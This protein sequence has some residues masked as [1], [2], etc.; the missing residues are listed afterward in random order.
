MKFLAL[1]F[2][3]CVTFT[4]S[5]QTPNIVFDS[6]E[7]SVQFNR[8]GISAIYSH[9]DT[10]KANPVRFGDA[11]GKAN[12]VYK[13]GSGAWL[14]VNT[15]NTVINRPSPNK[16]VYSNSNE[17]TTMNLYRTFEKFDNKVQCKIK[18]V[19][20]VSFPQTI[21][22]FY[23]DFPVNTPQ[24]FS[25]PDDI[26]EQ[27]YVKHQYIGGNG[28][29]L[30]YTRGSGQPPF[31]VV[32]PNKGTH[33]EYFEN[34]DIYI[35]SALSASKHEKGS[36]R[37]ENSEIVLAPKGE[38][39][40]S[41]EYGFV[42]EWANSYEEIRDILYNNGLFDIRVIPGMTIPKD[43]S[44]KISIRTKNHIDSIVAEYPDKTSITYLETTPDN[45]IYEIE[46]EQLGENLITIHYNHSEKTILEFFSTE[47]IDTLIQ[48][49]AN[50]IAESQQHKD[51]TKWYNGLYSV[52]DMENKKLRGPDDTDGFDHWWGYVL[53]ADDP[54]LCKAP[55]L[56]AKNV[57]LPIDNEIES[58]EYYIEN[59]VW[60]GLQRTDK[61]YP[62]PY[63]IYG[64]PNWKV[65]R[66]G[67]AER[68]EIRNTN[69]D[70]MPV[71]RA[72]DYPHIFMLYYHMFQIAEF[73]PNKV[74]FR[75]AKGYLDLAYNTAK[76]YFT[77]PYE[78]LPYYEIYQWGY[79]NELVL[80]P[81]IDDLEKYG[82]SDEA[83]W[84]R[85]EWEKKVKY[86]IYDDKYPYR[87]EYPFDRTAFESSYALAKYGVLNKMKP[88]ENLWY[89][90]N[91]E[92]WYSH[93][94]VN[95]DDSRDFM[96]R[97]H[98]AG[99]A[100]RGW[101]EPAYY[102]Y[103]ADFSLSY[104][105]RMGG[106]SI[107]DYGLNFSDKPWDWIQLGYASYLSS[108]ALINTGNEE[109]NYGYWY[110][111]KEN[112][113]ATGWAYNNKKYGSIWLQNRDHTRGAWN[114]DG[115]ADLGN[116]AIFRMS[117][118]ILAKDPLFGW[119]AFGGKMDQKD[120]VLSVYPRDGVRNRF[121]I[122]DENDKIG[123][124]VNRDG[125]AKGT[126]VLYSE[127][128]ETV[129]F[130]LENRLNDEHKTTLTLK[131]DDDWELYLDNQKI[132]LHPTVRKSEK[133]MEAL[134]TVKSNR[135]NIKLKK[136][137]RE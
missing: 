14:N 122:I 39:G 126:P 13:V 92:K 72:Y 55:F 121:W 67:V 64:V 71:W 74:K 102:H 69:L 57:Y 27:G 9:K 28:S 73:Y 131:S 24:N 127:A 103:G 65:N 96:E 47:P 62:Y 82:M 58:I 100:I 70:K 46:F 94:K 20:R 129:E 89:D 111:G 49:R 98:Y 104:M 101:I 97:Q 120:K 123:I 2:F 116:G 17:G 54:G 43:L 51:P 11:W 33:F 37:Q 110:P 105:A 68:A 23:F 136:N 50:F 130:Y 77:Y 115:E 90:V 10:L 19:S 38:E 25:K 22:D 134:I 132:S 86:F 88:D 30:F 66:G 34:D 5:S 42:F 21:G 117:S 125:F 106:W 1:F 84:L 114:Y 91:R 95:Q 112:D 85:S 32:T 36:W 81:L 7:M 75:D 93:N 108:F 40:S 78:I 31:L 6:E 56:A 53:A 3:L 52:W 79:Y 63:G 118:T 8:T 109:T 119:F 137:Y 80:M 133:V 4:T 83:N 124:E 99:L 18:A 12:I 59:Y 41:V 113:G 135:H 35:H 60:G 29:F 61:E 107:L 128:D 26:F 76:A 16:I 87:S 44:C 48:K 15:S 45:N